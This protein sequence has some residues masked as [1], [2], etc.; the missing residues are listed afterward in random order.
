M[1]SV[2]PMPSIAQVGP[3]GVVQMPRLWCKVLLDAKGQLA[4]GYFA[5]GPGFDKR[6]LDGIEINQEVA[7]AYLR[8][9]LPTYPEFEAWILEQ[10]G[11]SLSSAMVQQV[12]ESIL[13]YTSTE[14]RLRPYKQGIGLDPDFPTTAYHWLIELDDWK[15]F[16]TCLMAGGEGIAKWVPFAV[17]ARGPL[18][19]VQLPR[20]W[21]KVLLDARGLLPDGYVP[22]GNGLDRMVLEGLSVERDPVVDFLTQNLPTYLEFE[23]WI[24]GQRDPITEDEVDRVNSQILGHVSP[25]RAAILEATGMDPNLDETRAHALNR[26][27]DWAEFHRAVIGG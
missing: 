17:E 20:L 3:L 1:K 6:M 19:V 9:N 25:R 15:Q 16:H 12:N 18:G 7:T 24:K 26:Y 14:E 8:D 11:G 10:K 13:G 21:S 5:S 23:Q 22:C 4:E 27:D 2:P